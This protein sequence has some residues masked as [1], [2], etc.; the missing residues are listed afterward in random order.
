MQKK[1]DTGLMWFRRDLRVQDNAALHHAL[2]ACRQLFCV[3]VFD[4]D[5]LD[6][7]P[8]EDRRVEFIRESLV[9]L[10]LQLCQLGAA[11]QAPDAGLIV[12]HAV[13]SDAVA[14]L[15]SELKAN[16]VFF[17]HDYEPQALA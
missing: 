17:N 15:A 1:Y 11:H 16:A 5:I 10:H 9:E 2:V 4:R 13:A 8:R 7:L 14:D 6:D 12:L 3:F